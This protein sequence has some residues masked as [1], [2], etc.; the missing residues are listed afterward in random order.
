MDISVFKTGKFLL[1]SDTKLIC[2]DC[3]TGH[4][5]SKEKSI[6][7]IEYKKYNQEIYGKTIVCN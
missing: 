2:P 4:L 7:R 1:N 3:N 5:I 6:K